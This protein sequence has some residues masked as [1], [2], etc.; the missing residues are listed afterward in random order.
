LP[1]G[2]RFRLLHAIHPY[3]NGIFVSIGAG[4]DGSF[5]TKVIDARE[6]EGIFDLGEERGIA[7]SL[8]FGGEKDV[9]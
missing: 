6:G 9:G 2:H 3:G 4:D 5:E 7:G 1:R 8:G